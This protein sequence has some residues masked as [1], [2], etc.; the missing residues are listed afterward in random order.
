LFDDALYVSTVVGWRVWALLEDA[1]GPRLSSLMHPSAWTIRRAFEASCAL[2]GEP[3][4]LGRRRVPAHETAPHPACA[5]GI[6]AAADVEHALAYLGDS[7][8][9]DA[10]V[11]GQVLGRVALWGNVV[12]GLAG[13]R[14]EKGYPVALYL[15]TVGLDDPY[16]VAFGLAEYRVPPV[17]PE[18]RAQLP[19]P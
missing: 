9:G 17:A 16:E 6:H 19:A 13:W 8:E 7:S 11:R 5:C 12:E 10:V 18:V 14:A 2:R 3:L 4:I 15:P 1:D